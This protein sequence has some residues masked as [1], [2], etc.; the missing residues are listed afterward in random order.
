VKLVGF[1][2]THPNGNSFTDCHGSL[3]PSQLHMVTVMGF[4]PMNTG[5]KTLGLK[6]LVDTAMYRANKHTAHAKIKLCHNVAAS[7]L[8]CGG[9]ESSWGGYLFYLR[10]Y[11]FLLLFHAFPVLLCSV[12]TNLTSFDNLAAEFS[13]DDHRPCW[14]VSV[15]FT[16]RFRVGYSHETVG[17]SQS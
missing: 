8:T 9:L 4:E 7:I 14:A 16:T 13:A 17:A 10:F 2:P 3:T 1:A 11:G 15:G 5:L 12:L 6:P